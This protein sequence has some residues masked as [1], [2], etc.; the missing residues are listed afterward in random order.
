M[1]KLLGLGIVY[2]KLKVYTKGGGMMM[3]VI[4]IGIVIVIIIYLKPYNFLQ[5]QKT[6][7]IK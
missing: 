2:L 7:Y 1:Y 3:I 5:K 4:I 6:D